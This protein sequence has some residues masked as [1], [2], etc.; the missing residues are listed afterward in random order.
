MLGIIWTSVRLLG[1]VLL[2]GMLSMVFNACEI[3][4]NRGERGR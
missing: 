3:P 2:S 1:K 4:Y